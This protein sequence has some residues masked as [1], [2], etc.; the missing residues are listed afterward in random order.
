MKGVSSGMAV[1]VSRFPDLIYPD[2]IEFTVILL[3][4]PQAAITAIIDTLPI[5]FRGG[6]PV[7]N[8]PPSCVQ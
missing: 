8:K 1:V 5:E 6:D 3:V 2:L 4:N 7:S